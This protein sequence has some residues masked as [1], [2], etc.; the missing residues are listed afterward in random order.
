M[1]TF[2]WR[3]GAVDTIADIAADNYERFMPDVVNAC[4]VEAPKDSLRLSS[5]IRYVRAGRGRTTVFRVV[6]RA[7][8][9]E[10][11]NYPLVN[12]YGRKAV[13]ASPGKVL[14]F[15]PKGSATVIYRKSVK[16]TRPNNYLAR[17]LARAGCRQVSP[18]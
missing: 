5:N 18:R 17:G 12:I 10:G 9:D 7:I 8:S 2:D 16:A 14:K 1:A 11:Y 6:S 15:T 3:P 13:T 4:V